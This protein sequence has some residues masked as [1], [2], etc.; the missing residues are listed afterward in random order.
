MNHI[1]LLKRAFTITWRYRPLWIF[2]F[3]LALC[4]GGGGGGG[5]NF[6]FP[7]GGSNDFDDFNNVSPIYLPLILL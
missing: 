6:N 1:D 7:S 4:G 3:F 5:G 2:G